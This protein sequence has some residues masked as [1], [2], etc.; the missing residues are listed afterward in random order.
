MTKKIGVIVES[1]GK[2]K[3]IS[4]IL[5]DNYIVEASVGHVQDLIKKN[6]GIYVDNNFKMTYEVSSDKKKVVANLIKLVKSCSE[7]I[8]AADEDREGEAIAA[9]RC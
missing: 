1:P 8:L 2:I 6:L 4:A 7:I 3:K 5:G 9:I